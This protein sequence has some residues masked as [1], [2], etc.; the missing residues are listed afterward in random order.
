MPL[1][2]TLLKNKPPPSLS[3]ENVGIGSSVPKKSEKKI[4]S[5][6]ETEATTGDG[7]ICV[8]IIVSKS[9]EVVCYA[10]AGEDFVDLLFSFLI[11]PLGYI[12][13]EMRGSSS[14]G[15]IDALYSSVE[16][17]DADRYMKSEEHKAMLLSPKV[18]PGFRCENQLLS[19]NEA[20]YPPYFFHAFN[21]RHR[22]KL[23]SDENLISREFSVTAL[24]V[25]DPRGYLAGPAM[26][27]VLDNL[28][29]MPISPVSGIS[30]LN[31]LG[32]PFGD[33]EERIVHVGKEEV[34]FSS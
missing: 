9:K 34:F 29:I 28:V 17:L 6:M 3:N 13:K 26:F 20:S 5:C 8:K 23:T 11:L 27:T 10:E 18:A 12:V 7:K 2:E 15:C 32:V 24:T 21:D 19:I 22:D 31:K 33:V 14:K 25:M 1:T 4:R 16:N 30:I